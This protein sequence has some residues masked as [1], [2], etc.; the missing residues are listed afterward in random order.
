MK[1]CLIMDILLKTN[2]N[3]E[4]GLIGFSITVID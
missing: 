4:E 3:Q 2:L 1:M